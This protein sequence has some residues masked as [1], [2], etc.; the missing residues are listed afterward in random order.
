VPNR[1]D[2]FEPDL[3]RARTL[4][5]DWYYDPALYERERRRVFGRS[6]QMVGRGNQVRLPGEYFTCS[7]ADED[8]VVTRAG[9]LRALSA[10]CRHRAGPVARGFGQRK[11]LQC[12]YHGW[13]YALDGQLLAAP[14]FEGVD[15]FDVSRIC[16]PSFRVDEWGGFVFVNLSADGP[17]LAAVLGAIPAET[18]RLPLDRLSLYKRVDYEVACNWKTYIDNF[19][20]AYHVPQVHPGL[21]KEMDFTGSRVETY[22]GY[23]R[24]RV[25]LRPRTPDALFGRSVSDGA[26]AEA[27]YYWVFPNLMLS[28]YPDNLQVNVV[29]PLA[30]E[31]TQTR[32][33][34]YVIDPTRA[35][36]AQGF[37][38]SFAFAEQ[39]QREDI[40]ICEAVQRGLRSRTYSSGRYSV[41]RESGVHHF[42]A[43]L[44]RFME[45][46]GAGA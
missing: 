34:W 27:L 7:V 5:S 44:A 25:P 33:E 14:G 29:Q 42:H 2:A 35:G 36:V 28:V 38:R 9:S 18:R 40:A 8:L 16:L 17:G 1:T 41:Q 10:V 31:R 11:A 12:G 24:Q 3:S 46:A 39:V 6:W 4:R 13:T 26:P 30:P 21:L 19:L 23:S 20:E 37:E 43:L 22:D 45:P 15:G 32:L